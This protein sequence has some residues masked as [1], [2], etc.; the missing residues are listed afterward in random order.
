MNKL[1]AIGMVLFL[2]GC[3]HSNPILKTEI[4]YEAI[5]PPEA[6]FFCPE[7]PE[8]PTGDYTQRDVARTIVELYETSV[9]CKSSLNSVKAF[10]DQSKSIIEEQE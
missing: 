3:S 8:L 6:L 5:T 2:V 7:I 4:K 10:I 9:T 1:I